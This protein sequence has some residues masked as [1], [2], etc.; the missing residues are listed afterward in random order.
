MRTI[1]TQAKNTREVFPSEAV[2]GRH[3]LIL[4]MFV[5]RCGYWTTNKKWLIKYL[6]AGRV[7]NWHVLR[8][9]SVN[10]PEI[11]NVYLRDGSA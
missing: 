11:C 1:L 7:I 8:Q 4:L 10:A 3:H 9:E 2:I 5:E 6:V